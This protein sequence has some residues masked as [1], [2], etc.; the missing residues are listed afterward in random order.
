MNSRTR[1][2]GFTLI[3]LLVVIAIIAILIGLLVPAVQK[4]RAA[5]SRTT[6]INNLKQIALAALNYES[7]Y[8]KLPPG[9]IGLPSSQDTATFPT[10]TYPTGPALSGPF[11]G[12]LAL[13][14]PYIEQG[15]L[16]KVMRNGMPA[17]YFDP[18]NS[19]NTTPWWGYGPTWSAAN[20]TVPEFL[21][22]D[23]PSRS[24][25]Q[26]QGACQVMYSTAPGSG[27]LRFWIFNGYQTLGRTNYVGVA[28]Y[29]GSVFPNTYEGVFY[30]RSTL[31]LAVI[32]NRDGTSNTLMFGEMIGDTKAGAGYSLTWMGNGMWATAWGLSDNYQWYQF[33]SNHTGIVNFAR[34]DGSVCQIMTSANTSMYYAA[35]G[36]NDGVNI[37]W[38]TLTN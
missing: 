34:C 5:A 4:V 38:S 24:S 12:V 13:L 33:S 11:V 16:D 31:K 19:S 7:S 21:C 37:D 8:K 27:T 6:C 1:R 36:F 2:H 17:G 14:L 35:G 25:S 9:E 10:A 32:T 3:E 23:D 15:P 30:N 20:N 18:S 28:G 29:L 26:Y 22:P